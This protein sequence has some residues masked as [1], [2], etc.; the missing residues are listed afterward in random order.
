MKNT[1]I[2]LLATA[3]L[4]FLLHA[5]GIFDFGSFID[6][7]Y[8]N[9]Y[10]DKRAQ[11]VNAAPTWKLAIAYDEQ[12]RP[13]KDSVRGAVLAAELINKQGGVLG[14]PI[15]LIIQ[16][17]TSTLP[18]YNAAVQSFCKDLSVAAILGPYR[19]GDIPSAR[20]LTQFQ[21]LP[22]VSPITVASEKLPAL[23][24][25][26]FITF[27]PPLSA[28][29]EVLLSDME[30]RGFREV[31]LICP[32]SGSYG[33][34]FCTAIE[35]ASRN[36]LGGCHVMRINYQS[37]LR[38]HKISNTLR[39]YTHENGIDAIF[40]GGKHA[41]YIE[42]GHLMNTL[43]IS[44]PTYISDDAYLPGNMKTP[45]VQELLLPMVKIEDLPVEFTQAWHATHGEQPPSYH[46]ALNAVTV[47]AMAQAIQ[48]NKGYHP[49]LLAEKLGKLR[50]A[51]AHSIIL[52]KKLYPAQ[53]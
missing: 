25:E 27:F 11:A 2:T 29:V 46:A 34:I 30:K 48:E 47:Y 20:A 23:E 38:M 6:K 49:T 32:E 35:R 51:R 16:N 24:P 50:D 43:G 5:L 3:L 14:R 9:Q 31:L 18:Q 26:N 19:S 12:D 4:I 1:I 53:K 42:F 52:D 28:W 41:D 40:F 36:R 17:N 10:A 44:R 8:R 39:T 13:I 33:D 45:G 21:G 15:E 22:L 37:P 7:E